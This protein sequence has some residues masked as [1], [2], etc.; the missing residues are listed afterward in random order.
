MVHGG[1]LGICHQLPHCILAIGAVPM[2]TPPLRRLVTD[3]RPINIYAEAFRVKYAAIAE[4][5]LMLVSRAMLWVRD[6]KNAYHL[7]CLGGCRGNT[8][9]LVLWITNDEGSGYVPTPTF[10]SGCWTGNCLG[11]RQSNVLNVR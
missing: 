9:K 5:C 4:I 6:L 11:V 2:A 7:I 10:Q 1:Q 3:A 8:T